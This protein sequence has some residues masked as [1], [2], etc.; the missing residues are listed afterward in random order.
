MAK[1]EAR[2]R[3]RRERR[4]FAAEEGE[5]GEDDGSRENNSGTA[6]ERAADFFSFFFFP[7][8]PSHHRF[9][10]ALSFRSLISWSTLSCLPCFF[11]SV[12]Q[13]HRPLWACSPPS[14]PFFFSAPRETEGFPPFFYSVLLSEG[15]TR[16]LVR[17]NPK[18]MRR[19]PRFSSLPTRA[20][21]RR[22]KVQ[23]GVHARARRAAALAEP[24]ETTGL[25]EG[26]RASTGLRRE[27]RGEATEGG[28]R[29]DGGEDGD[30]RC[31]KKNSR[32][33]WRAAEPPPDS[34][35]L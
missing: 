9:Y 31:T 21:E 26:G 35:D 3:A 22:K 20:R 30:I 24:P 1:A 6:P 4:G 10:L 7:S 5:G 16:G 33:Y 14:R 8:G 23:E 17:N 18:R 13:A 29:E 34:G 19:K 15:P 32:P 27:G 28:R 25:G 12:L 2:N 11:R